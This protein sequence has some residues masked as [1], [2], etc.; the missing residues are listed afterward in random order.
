MRMRQVGAG[1][2]HL[3]LEA[4]RRRGVAQVTVPV[5]VWPAAV[6]VAVPDPV[7]EHSTT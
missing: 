2:G 6:S 4:A 1:L 5:A 3:Q 7:P